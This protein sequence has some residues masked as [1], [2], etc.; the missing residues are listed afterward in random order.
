MVVNERRT[1][2]IGPVL[3][4]GL[5]FAAA[6]LAG[7]AQ[8]SGPAPEPPKAV[9]VSPAD[10]AAPAPRAWALRLPPVDKVVFR[11]GVSHDAAGLGAGSMLYGAPGV[12]GFFAAVLTHG[13]I[14]SA[15]REKQK[16]QLQSEADRVLEP[17]VPVLNAFTHQQLMADALARTTVGGAKRLVAAAEPVA[18]DWLIESAPVFSMTQDQRAI[19]LDNVLRIFA[20]GGA[21][22]VYAQTVRV[23]SVPLV[24]PVASAARAASAASEPAGA[25]GMAP[26][27][28]ESQGRRVTDESVALFAESLDIALREAAGPAVA[29]TAPHKTF[30]YPEGGSE[31]MERAQLVAERC[32]R[33]LI[34][35]LRG[36][37][38]SIPIGP[39]GGERCNPGAAAS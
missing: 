9:I 2:P 11:G 37:L 39:A 27:W 16:D 33:T 30:R 8:D 22:V 14:T 34:R 4:V 24:L 3:F 23:V 25:S 26:V 10:P 15:L 7:A 1:T 28:L 12:A 29:D 18:A 20:P 21:T 19:V 13:L 35:T 6:R 36:W 31:K 38:M 17:F 32:G 5:L